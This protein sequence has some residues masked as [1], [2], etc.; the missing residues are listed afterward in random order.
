[1]VKKQLL[2]RTAAA[3][4]LGLSLATGA[5]SAAVPHQHYNNNKHDGSS[6]QM[7]TNNKVVLSSTNQQ[8]NVS[9]SNNAS[10]VAQSG[11]A[12]VTSNWSGKGADASTGNA[13]NDSELTKAIV[14]VSNGGQSNGNGSGGNMATDETPANDPQD[15]TNSNTVKVTNT[16]QQNN[17]QVSNNVDQYASTG[18]AVVAHNGKGGDATTG[19]AKNTSTASFD[20]EVTN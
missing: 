7:P 18:D 20:V 14:N 2:Y 1:M 13:K 6:H 5:A 11:D 10:Q 12:T 9:A 17:V 8:N 3:T 19:N 15:N 4:V 16:N